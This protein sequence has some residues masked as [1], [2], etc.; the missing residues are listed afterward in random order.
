MA[1]KPSPH[2]AQPSAL[3][4]LARVGE[5]SYELAKTPE[6]ALE[7]L[8]D[9]SGPRVLS[10]SQARKASGT[11]PLIVLDEGGFTIY[12]PWRS[13]R[14]ATPDA[15]LGGDFAMGTA[16]VGRLVPTPRGSHLELSV[17]RYA[18]TPVRR[19]TVRVT[20][21]SWAF[22]VIAPVLL[23]G[24]HPIALAL[25]AFMLI[26]GVASVTLRER[27]RRS[28]DVRDLL[29]IVERIYGPHELSS[30]EDPHRR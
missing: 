2:P 30:A 23:A 24:P 11:E 26:G 4:S 10:W 28:Q 16:V 14:D 9:G 17:K 29:A 7:L 19:V 12:K 25:S 3:G 27:R 5:R 21:T 13:P 20:V 18:P 1:L 22:F 6:A 8:R 15:A